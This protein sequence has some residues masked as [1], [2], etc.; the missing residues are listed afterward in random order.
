MDW[1]WIHDREDLSERIHYRFR[2][3]DY[4][5]LLIDGRP[6]VLDGN[7][8]DILHNSRKPR[9]SQQATIRAANCP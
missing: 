3:G 4:Y 1:K 7:P 8:I 5:K 9:L 2:D 6:S